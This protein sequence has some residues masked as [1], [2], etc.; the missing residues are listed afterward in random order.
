M[1][2]ILKNETSKWIAKWSRTL[3]IQINKKVKYEKHIKNRD[4]WIDNQNKEDEISKFKLQKRRRRVRVTQ[5][6]EYL[7]MDN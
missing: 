6:R 2:S 3:K 4:I 7:Q 1:T 5:T